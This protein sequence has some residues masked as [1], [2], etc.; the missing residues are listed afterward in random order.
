MEF[1]ASWELSPDQWLW[2]GFFALCIG[3]AKT[4]LGGAGMLVVP[5]MAQIFGARSSTGLVLLLLIMADFFGVGYYHRH[6]DFRQ[7]IRLAPATIVGVLL[8]IWVGDRINEAQFQFLLAGVILV[9]IVLMVINFQKSNLI[10]QNTSIALLAGLAGGFTTMIGNAAGPVMTIYLLSMGFKKN[11]FI[12][13]AAW[14]FLLVNLFKVPFHIWIWETISVDTLLFDLT[15]FP[16]IMLGAF[17]GVWVVRRIPER[18]YRIFL[19]VS[20]ALASLKLLF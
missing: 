19:L 8:A 15:L 4:G 14:F 11:E 13:T 2:G 10:P 1:L 6:A 12:G 9:G 7:I 16:L 18:P 20:I 3:M 5:I 17:F